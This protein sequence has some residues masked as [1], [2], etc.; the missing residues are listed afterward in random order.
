MST[1]GS[2]CTHQYL[3]KA[4]FVCSSR[5]LTPMTIPVT[6]FSTQRSKSAISLYSTNSSDLSFRDFKPDSSADVPRW[7]FP[8]LSMYDQNGLV[9][10]QSLFETKRTKYPSGSLSDRRYSCV[11]DAGQ[12][13][14]QHPVLESATANGAA[15]MSKVSRWA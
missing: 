2:F 12:L 8:T 15:V 10:V 6:A 9:G 1:K 7:A 4:T 11:R 3:L 14:Q 13:S 5:P